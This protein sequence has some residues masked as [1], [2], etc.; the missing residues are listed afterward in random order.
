MSSG[1]TTSWGFQKDPVRLDAQGF[2]GLWCHLQ[3]RMGE[4]VSCGP[5]AGLIP[6][7][8]ASQVGSIPSEQPRAL[9]WPQLRGSEAHLA[10]LTGPSPTLCCELLSGYLPAPPIPAPAHC[11]TLVTSIVT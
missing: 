2:E 7:D 11:T 10:Q 8:L 3:D 6:S 4:A 5:L 1:K 9:S